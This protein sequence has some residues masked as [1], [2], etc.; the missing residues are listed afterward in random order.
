M[1]VGSLTG[2][3]AGAA[4]TPTAAQTDAA[5]IAENFDSFLQLLTTQL[6]NQNPLEP[7]DTNEF[8]NQL[9]QARAVIGPPQRR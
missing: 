2:V 1:S 5:A 6:K 7:M 3:F 8:T 4:T 9:V